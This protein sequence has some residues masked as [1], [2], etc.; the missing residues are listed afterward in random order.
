MLSPAIAYRGQPI[1]LVAADT[2]EAAIEAAALVKATY[3]AEPIS[4]TLD[5]PG[6]E[7]INQADTPL[8]NFIPEVIAGDA[9]KAFADALVKI[10]ATFTSPPQHQNP[11]ELIATVAEWREDRLIIHEGTQNATRGRARSCARARG[12]DLS[13]R[14]HS[15]QMQAAVAARRLARP[16]KL[17]VPRAQI[18]HDASF[19]PANRHRIRLGAD[20]SGKMVAAIHEVDAQTSRHDLFPGAYTATSSRLH[21]FEHFRGRERLVRTDVQTPGYMRAPFEHAA[22]F[23]M[24]CCVDELA[25]KLD[26]DPVALRLAND[27]ATD[28]VSK[29]PLSSRHLSECLQRGA[30]RFGWGKPTKSRPWY[31]PCRRGLRPHQFAKRDGNVA[32]TNP[33]RRS[34]RRQRQ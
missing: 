19:R 20:R 21:G 5:A 12:G 4:V 11:I 14:L 13:L 7:T 17:V 9:D 8:K 6:T 16:V 28:P 34:D 3:A 29:L 33:G 24:E 15:L 18:F 10:D 30:E 23:A 2:L 22:C 1:A 31:K 27:T 32:A 26:Q 25:Y